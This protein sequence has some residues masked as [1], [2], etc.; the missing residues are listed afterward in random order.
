ML[1]IISIL[2][3]H[4]LIISLLALGCGI[5]ITSAVPQVGQ[6]VS[7]GMELI[8]NG[9]SYFVPFLIY[10]LLTPSL[11]K[12][13]SLAKEYGNGWLISVLRQFI[14]ARVLAILFAIIILT[15]LFRLNFHLNHGITLVMA[16]NQA[17]HQLIDAFFFSH[18]L[19]GVYGAIAT[20]FLARKFIGIHRFFEYV[21]KS[22]ER[23]GVFLMV[24]SP[25]FMFAVGGFLLELPQYLSANLSSSFGGEEASVLSILNTY[26]F[27]LQYIPSEY[28]FVALYILIGLT[29][30]AMCLLWHSL[31]I[32]YTKLA[33]PQFSV[34]YYLKY[35]WI[36]VYPLLW[37]SSSESLAVPLS[38][39]LMKKNFPTVPAA[40]RQF[41]ITGGS[42][43]GINGTL[44]SVYVMAVFIAKVLGVEISFL[45]LLVSLPVV[46][47]LGYAVP[48]IPGELII[49]A[50][51]M[52]MLLGIPLALT[53]IF[54]AL[55]LTLQIGL[56]DSFRTGCNSTDSG[57]LAIVATH[58]LE[59]IKAKQAMQKGDWSVEGSAE[60]L[61]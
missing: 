45:Q 1:K 57:L 58:N 13:E 32:M 39:N 51:S 34:K 3:E 19:Y 7:G 43:L 15:F 55:Y 4:S 23:L 44:I 14:V 22:I 33:M 27:G 54:M 6:L 8:V 26:F 42:Y 40:V 11:I 30:G 46:F 20:T 41:V 21:G 12:I 17:G 2:E 36:K 24:L 49:F 60:N 10:F 29:T 53:P 61:R 38:L 59:K 56:S 16:M 5:V 52:N 25:L 28:S 31:Y 50:S 35:Y 47:V 18:V 9:Y 48:G 37:A